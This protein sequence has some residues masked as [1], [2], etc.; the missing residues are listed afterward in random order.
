[1][2]G[3]YRARIVIRQFADEDACGAVSNDETPGTDAFTS[4]ASSGTWRLGGR[5]GAA[6]AIS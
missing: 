6:E 1:V 5:F 3:C 2:A 4:T